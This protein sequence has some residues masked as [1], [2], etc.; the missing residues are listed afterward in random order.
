MKR[1][2]K[3][4]WWGKGLNVL[5]GSFLFSFF[6]QFNSFFRLLLPFCW[7]MIKI[8]NYWIHRIDCNE[9]DKIWKIKM[10]EIFFFLNSKQGTRIVIIKRS[11]EKKKKKD[12][13]WKYVYEATAES[14]RFV[15]KIFENRVQEKWRKTNFILIVKTRSNS[16][17][18]V[19]LF[20]C[21]LTFL[22]LKFNLLI[23]FFLEGILIKT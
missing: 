10:K 5:L 3:N 6:N 17:K 9:E 2:Y 13:S 14:F 12:I 7:W 4:N 21:F 8:P 1:F 16:F 11:E 19:I 22:L 20:F 15:Y 18:V 23:K